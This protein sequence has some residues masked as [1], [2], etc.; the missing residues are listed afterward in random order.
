M[1][2][3]NPL[4]ISQLMKEAL[5]RADIVITTGGLGPT[6]DDPTREA[7]ALAF[8]TENEFHPDYGSKSS[9]VF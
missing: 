5:T 2:G 8:D 7:A 4:R 9:N 3:D 1:V 6:V